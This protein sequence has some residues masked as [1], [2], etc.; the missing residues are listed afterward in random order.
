MK[1]LLYVII[2]IM[3]L[4]LA[5]PSFAEDFNQEEVCV[6]LGTVGETIMGLRNSGLSETE[7]Q[8]VI[9]EAARAGAVAPDIEFAI[10]NLP[11][12]AFDGRGSNESEFGYYIYEQCMN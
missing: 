3:I 4:A 5:V 8:K 11:P 10:S 7:V 6:A 2:T 9:M 12:Q 1:S